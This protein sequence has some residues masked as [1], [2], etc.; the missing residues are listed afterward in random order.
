LSRAHAPLCALSLW[1]FLAPLAGA[2]D[3][4]VATDGNDGNP[5][6]ESQPWKTLQHAAD[7]VGP[8]DTVSV[9]G[10]NYAGAYLETSGTSSQPIVFQAFAGET[11]TLFVDGGVYRDSYDAATLAQVLA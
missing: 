8:G 7:T 2:A 6:S 9:H 5:G 10:G 3:Y 4:F 1:L 11:P